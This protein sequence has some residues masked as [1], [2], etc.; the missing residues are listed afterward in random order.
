VRNSSL[1][2]RAICLATAALCLLVADVHGLRAQVQSE[3]VGAPVTGRPIEGGIDF[4]VHSAPDAFGRNI[5]D[6][7][8]AMFAARQGMRAIVLKNHVTMTA[9]RAALV[10][11]VVP[12]IR[13]YGGMVL[14]RSV[15]G[16]N[17]EAIEAMVRIPG[18]YG[19]VVWL[20]TIDS[21]NYIDT[22][23]AGGKA[24]VRDGMGYRLTDDNGEVIPDVVRVLETVREHDLVIS[25]G[26]ADP[27]ETLAV[28]RLA[29]EMGIE[30]IVVTHAMATVPGLSLEQLQEAADL[31]AYLELVFVNDLMGPDSHL[32]WMHPWNRVTIEE[33]A[34]AVE[35]V[36]AE[37]FILGSDL[38]QTGNPIHTDGFQ[39]L[40]LGL[41][42]AGIP[43][44]DVVTMMT[45][46]PSRLLG[47][48]GID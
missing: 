5:S 14:N 42:D 4:H 13:V 37:H 25:T 48:D 34:T 45:D 10:E 20:P 26:H 15:G 23:G 40:V 44:D 27:E 46:N 8:A 35:A 41:Q 19:K 24:I 21:Q 11:Q 29:S 6:I 17:A 3:E 12:N 22:F 1:P 18:G 39:A 2:P 47:I 28:V 33:M 43:R 36:G 31:G 38:G 30:K 9:D 7:D 32:D 16:L